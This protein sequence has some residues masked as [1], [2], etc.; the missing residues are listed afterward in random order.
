MLYP[1]SLNPDRWN[2]MSQCGSNLYAEVDFLKGLPGKNP[3]YEDLQPGVF[4]PGG[5]GDTG[6]YYYTS[7]GSI[8]SSTEFWRVHLAEIG[9]KAP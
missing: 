8:W 1:E 5:F 3:L 7:D 9:Y 6:L 4:Y 2:A